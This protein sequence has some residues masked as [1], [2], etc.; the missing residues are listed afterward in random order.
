M[1]GRVIALCGKIREEF[2]FLILN[3]TEEYDNAYIDSFY[4]NPVVAFRLWR[5]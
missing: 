3:N 5:S 4:C 1:A 2:V